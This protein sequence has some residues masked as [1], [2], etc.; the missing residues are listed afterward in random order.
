MAWTNQTDREFYF[1]A[2]RRGSDEKP[3]H[4]STIS[5]ALVVTDSRSTVLPSVAM[6]DCAPADMEVDDACID[7]EA[8]RMYPAGPVLDE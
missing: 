7:D 6:S 2:T 5:L 1:L 8:E 4:S 3:G